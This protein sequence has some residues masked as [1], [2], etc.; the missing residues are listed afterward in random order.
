MSSPIVTEGFRVSCRPVKNH[1][2]EVTCGRSKE[3]KRKVP[4][5]QT[6]CETS[7]GDWSRERRGKW[8]VSVMRVYFKI[9]RLVVELCK[10]STIL[11]VLQVLLLYIPSIYVKVHLLKIFCNLWDLTHGC[12]SPRLTRLAPFLLS[13]IPFVF[14]SLLSNLPL[15]TR[16][17]TL[18]T[19]QHSQYNVRRLHIC[20]L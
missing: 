15:N 5:V 13:F 20:L 9:E 8:K 6:Q 12:P 3:E 11:T 18:Y 19:N 4:V 16:F 1:S 14:F 2:T 17:L 7:E 10:M